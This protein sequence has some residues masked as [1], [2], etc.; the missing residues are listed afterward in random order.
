MLLVVESWFLNK[1]TNFHSYGVRLTCLLRSESPLAFSQKLMLL[2]KLSRWRLMLMSISRYFVTMF[3][4]FVVLR[5]PFCLFLLVYLCWFC[6]VDEATRIFLLDWT[7]A[8]I[9]ASISWSC[10]LWNK[11]WRA[12]D[13]LP[14][15]LCWDAGE[16]S[17]LFL[18]DVSFAYPFFTI[19]ILRWKLHGFS[20][21]LNGC[22]RG[23]AYFCI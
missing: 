20:P 23:I 18:G 15:P 8:E 9:V 7:E 12:I 19:I 16:L 14:C 6:C 1:L 22:Y 21:L 2:L 5:Y 17:I 13:Q 10:N 3:Y 4:Y 11:L